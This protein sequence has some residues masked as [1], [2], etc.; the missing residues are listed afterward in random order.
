LLA[1]LRGW[2][3]AIPVAGLV[4]PLSA[5]FLWLIISFHPRAARLR[6]IQEENKPDAIEAERVKEINERKAAAALRAEIEAVKGTLP[7]SMSPQE[8]D[9]EARRILTL[10]A[11]RRVERAL[12]QRHVPT[13][14]EARER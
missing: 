13:V 7:N 14:P 12:Q 1:F 5:L 4:L 2:A 10:E 9:F 6:E 8:K 3:K 11:Q